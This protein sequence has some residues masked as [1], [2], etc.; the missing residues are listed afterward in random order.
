[1]W[2]WLTGGV[3][4]SITEIAKEWIDTDKESAEAKTLMV[5]A[6]DPNGHMRRDIS[7]KV[8]TMYQI[9]IYVTAVLVITQ[10]MGWGDTEGLKLAITNLTSLFIP[11]TT[12]FT[13]IVGASFGV[14]GLNVNKEKAVKE[15]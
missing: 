9:Y 6:L 10:A 4:N 1:M 3:T 5:K 7:A 11:I 15:K 14:N 2:K 12:M 13:A 8:S